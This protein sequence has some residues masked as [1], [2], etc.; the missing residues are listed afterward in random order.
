MAVALYRKGNTHTI[1][2]IECEMQRFD[3]Q[4]FESYLQEG[5]VIDPKLLAEPANEP[6]ND[7]VSQFEGGTI[8]PQQVRE[9]AKQAGIEGW[10]IKRIKTL[11]AE[12]NDNQG[13]DS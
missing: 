11:E 3:N 4:H 2:G 1:R 5:W 13:S 10:D 6:A 8:T 12:L 9:S 7:P